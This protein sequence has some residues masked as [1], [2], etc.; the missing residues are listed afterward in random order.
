MVF[1]NV[2]SN[3]QYVYA[4]WCAAFDCANLSFYTGSSCWLLY[5]IF[6]AYVMASPNNLVLLF[7]FKLQDAT[8]QFVSVMVQ[9]FSVNVAFAGSL[10]QL[11]Q[12]DRSSLGYIPGIVELGTDKVAQS[13]HNKS[14]AGDF[15]NTPSTISSSGLPAITVPGN[16]ELQQLPRLPPWFRISGGCKFY[17]ELAGILRL[18]GLSSMFGNINP[19]YCYCQYI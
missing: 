16:S 17:P 10:R 7:P 15:R 13:E 11:N 5:P 8:T 18:V 19:D 12:T 9:C 1:Q 2:S 3:L 14:L 6:L 4:L